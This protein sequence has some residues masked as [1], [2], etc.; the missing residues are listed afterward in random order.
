MWQ[1][2]GMFYGELLESIEENSWD[3]LANTWTEANLPPTWQWHWGILWNL[4]EEIK[5]VMWLNADVAPTLAGQPLGDGVLLADDLVAL[6]NY[7]LT[8]NWDS[9]TYDPTT[10]V[11]AP[12]MYL[13]PRINLQDQ[14]T[15]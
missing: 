12:S 10:G 4:P 3:Q 14:D 1:E 15:E 9:G 8:G 7:I 2:G 5:S 6:G 13:D 11:L